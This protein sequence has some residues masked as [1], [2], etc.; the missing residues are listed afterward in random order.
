MAGQIRLFEKTPDG[1][2]VELPPEQAEAVRRG[3]MVSRMAFEADVLWTPE[4]Q[5]AREAEEAATLKARE[6]R[7]RERAA[8]LAERMA[9][10]DAA[11]AKLEAMGLTVDEL[12]ALLG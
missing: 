5:A 6:T 11:K 2:L 10:A 12:R 9:Q 8:V 7:T 3:R 1:L 4:E